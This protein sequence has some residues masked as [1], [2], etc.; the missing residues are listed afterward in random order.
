[1]HMLKITIATTSTKQPII[2]LAVVPANSASFSIFLAQN[3]GSHIMY[4]GDASVST[5]NSIQLQPGGSL[6]ATPA[7]QF[8]GDL[9]EFWVIGTANDTLNVMIFD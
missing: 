6:T 1:M 2:P 9:T 3:N 4:L 7:L 8:T 5:T